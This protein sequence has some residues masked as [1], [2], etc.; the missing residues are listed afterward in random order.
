MVPSRFLSPRPAAV[1][2]AALLALLPTGCGGTPGVVVKGK[3]VYNGE[4]VP[5]TR[6][7][8]GPGD[9]GITINFYPLEPGPEEQAVFDAA[10]GTFEV[11]G[12]EGKGIRPGK[13]K[14][15]VVSG[16]WG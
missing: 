5:G 9:P 14:I 15:T 16:A 6:W 13:Y 10:T 4:P 2:A 1:L 12:A 7:K 3:L 8:L 11:R